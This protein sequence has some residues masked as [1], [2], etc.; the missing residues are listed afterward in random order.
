[1]QYVLVSACLLGRPVR[2]NGRAAA[3]DYPVLAAWESEG[4]L[5]VVCPEVAAG[6]PVPRPPAE[7]TA[8]QS[9][10]DVLQGKA[11]VLESGGRDVSRAFVSGAKQ[12]LAVA[13]E[14]NIQIAILKEGSPSCGSSFIYDGSFTGTKHA[15]AGVTAALLQDAGIRVFSE[16]ELDD[17]AAYAAYLKGSEAEISDENDPHNGM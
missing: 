17:A 14:K 2:Y 1:M 8:M 11:Q 7:I 10:R 15:Q 13:K 4:R 6:L 16:L 9:G 12:A 3:G 5:I